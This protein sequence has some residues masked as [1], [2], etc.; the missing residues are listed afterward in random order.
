MDGV[1]DNVIN[2]YSITDQ[3]AERFGPLFEA[4]NDRV[5]SRQAITILTKVPDQ[6]RSEYQLCKMGMYNQ[7]TG[8][9]APCGPIV[10]DVFYQL[11]V[12]DLE[13]NDPKIDKKL[14]K[15]KVSGEVR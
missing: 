12:V 5:A 3:A 15:I 2:L 14:E 11:K 9:I 6:F 7:K 8:E 10:V 4:V 13:G 1:N